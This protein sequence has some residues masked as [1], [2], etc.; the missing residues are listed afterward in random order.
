MSSKAEALLHI[1]G[2]YGSTE[3]FQQLREEKR[4]SLSDRHRDFIPHWLRIGHE[5]PWIRDAVDPPFSELSFH[6]CADQREM[7]EK[8]LHGNWCLGQAFVLD[9]IAMIQQVN[10]GDEWLTIKGYTRF[11]S[12]TAHSYSSTREQAEQ[13]L[14]RLLTAIRRSTEQECKA[15]EYMVNAPSPE[16]V[17]VVD[18]NAASNNP[19]SILK[20]HYGATTEDVTEEEALRR[21]FQMEA[22]MGHGYSLTAVVSLCDLLD[23][24][25]HTLYY[26]AQKALADETG[27]R[28][29]AERSFLQWLQE[30]KNR[31]LYGDDFRDQYEW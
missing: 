24:D 27:S 20:R 7:V 11:E 9:D 5:N 16:D 10:G 12:I 28:G 31:E 6:I 2:N 19:V 17:S 26:E 3:R 4:S 22:R 23:M 30:A 25:I 8:L 14:N 21:I 18:S 13:E 15:L 29:S 1:I